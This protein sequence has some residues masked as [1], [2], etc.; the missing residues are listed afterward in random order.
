MD[1][2][3]SFSGMSRHTPICA[4]A[5]ESERYV[6][7]KHTTPQLHP[8]KNITSEYRLLSLSNGL[9]RSIDAI[10][11][12]ASERVEHRKEQMEALSKEHVLKL[13]DAASRARASDTWAQ[14]KRLADSMTGA[15]SL[16]MGFSAARQNVFV[17]GTL[18]ALGLLSTSHTALCD[19]KAWDWLAGKFSDNEEIKKIFSTLLPSLFAITCIAILNGS[20]QMEPAEII[21]PFLVTSIALCSATAT[22]G[23]GLFEAKKTWA[24]ADL[25]T[26]KEALSLEREELQVI[27]N[28]L[29]K[30]LRELR[31][32]FKAA[33]QALQAA[34]QSRAFIMR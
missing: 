4:H 32:S 14:L 3:A 10:L 15:F 33:E 9:E 24:Q 11:H 6:S 34:A 2:V 19:S 12:T 29:E 22:M 17:G 8:P 16:L 13:R 1:K 30:L 26:I 23:K 7:W 21:K 5:D 25:D 28:T 18:I 27:T 31:L 20:S